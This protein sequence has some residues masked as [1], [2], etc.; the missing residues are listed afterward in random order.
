MLGLLINEQ[1]HNELN[2]LVK[3]ELEEILFDIGDPHIDQSV[4]QAMQER[5]QTL[6]RLL[7]RVA[8]EQECLA[9]MPKQHGL[10]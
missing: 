4:K 6:F 3:R 1:E 5:Y 9:Y 8:T 2:Y 10:K 7:R